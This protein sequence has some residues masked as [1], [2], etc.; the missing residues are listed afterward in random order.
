MT[1]FSLQQANWLLP[2]KWVFLLTLSVSTKAACTYLAQSP[3]PLVSLV[4]VGSV[5]MQGALQTKGTHNRL[6][7][8]RPPPDKAHQELIKIPET[9]GD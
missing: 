6:F 8:S 3:G 1:A 5:R 2:W 9:Q 7:Q 4:P